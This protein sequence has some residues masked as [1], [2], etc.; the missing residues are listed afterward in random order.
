MQVAKRIS[1][2][3]VSES[4]AQER[5]RA[6]AEAKKNLR[7]TSLPLSNQDEE[8]GPV[9]QHQL[10]LLGT[11][12]SSIQLMDSLVRFHSCPFRPSILCQQGGLRVLLTTH[13]CCISS[14]QDD[15]AYSVGS[16]D[17][18]EDDEVLA[19]AKG[20]LKHR[21]VQRIHSGTTKDDTAD[22]GSAHREQPLEC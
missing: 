17:E 14:C 13:G 2:L 18:E 9:M 11:K 16:E 8:V 5:E 21:N 1:E 15:E 7:I 3:E 22:H 10:R 19:L 6:R 12:V 20:V 4:K